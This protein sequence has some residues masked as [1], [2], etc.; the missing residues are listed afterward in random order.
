[1]E[2]TPP[3]QALEDLVCSIPRTHEAAL[4]TGPNDDPGRSA[5]MGSLG[6]SQPLDPARQGVSVGVYMSPGLPLSKTG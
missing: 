2:C 6:G 3:G 1:M 4:P 5:T